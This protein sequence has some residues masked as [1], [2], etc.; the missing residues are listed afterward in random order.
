MK[1]IA[2]IINYRLLNYW[3]TKLKDIEIIELIRA[4]AK[5]RSLCKK[6]EKEA[7]CYKKNLLRLG[8]SIPTLNGV[9]KNES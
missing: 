5:Q 7:A 3:R 6:F 1:L 4:Y 2:C 9:D 8:I